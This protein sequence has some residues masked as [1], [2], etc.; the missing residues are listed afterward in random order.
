MKST[1]KTNLLIILC[2]ILVIFNV[3]YFVIPVEHVDNFVYWFVYAISMLSLLSII[4]TYFIAFEKV[5]T[6]NSKILGYPLLK[7]GVIYIAIELSVSVLF[8]IL[9][10]FIKVEPWILIVTYVLLICV[11]VILFVTKKVARDEIV[12]MEKQVVEDKKFIK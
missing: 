3:L 8:S 12:I 7:V 4:G 2:A 5:K 1:L 10:L 11:F 6:L 9:N